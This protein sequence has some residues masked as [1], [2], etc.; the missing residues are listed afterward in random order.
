MA[1][2]SVFDRNNDGLK[3]FLGFLELFVRFYDLLD[4]RNLLLWLPGFVE[5]RKQLVGVH[6]VG[7]LGRH[8]AGRR[9]RMGQEPA[10][11]Q[12]GQLVSD[13][14]RRDLQPCALHQRAGADRL[15]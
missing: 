7:N 6:A 15:A 10:R 11:L 12:L 14:R 13:R 9:V 4:R 3:L 2:R 5:C 8:A 1:D